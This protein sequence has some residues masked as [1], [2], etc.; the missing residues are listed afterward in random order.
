MTFIE[1]FIKAAHQMSSD[2]Y[3]STWSP[4]VPALSHA[5]IHCSVI[6]AVQKRAQPLDPQV[7]CEMGP[8]YED[9]LV[10]DSLDEVRAE[11]KGAVKTE[12]APLSAALRQLR[13]TYEDATRLAAALG[14]GRHHGSK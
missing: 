14:V 10:A 4:R 8:P 6:P 1:R 12:L 7:G 5:A 11:V 13:S 9:D 3:V 2:G